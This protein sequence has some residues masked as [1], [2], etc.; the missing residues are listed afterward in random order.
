MCKKSQ[1]SVE[2]QVCAESQVCTAYLSARV[3]SRAGNVLP[4]TLPLWLSSVH[5]G[6]P[7]GAWLWLEGS[8]QTCQPAPPGDKSWCP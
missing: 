2:N 1:V 5:L 3:D 7:E 6:M 8:Q 4:R